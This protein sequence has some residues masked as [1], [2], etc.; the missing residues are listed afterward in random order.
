MPCYAMLCYAMYAMRCDAMRYDAVVTSA[1]SSS[2]SSATTADVDLGDAAPLVDA[3][4][5]QGAEFEAFVR[6]FVQ[7]PGSL[8]T[9]VRVCVR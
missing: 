5:L 9:L 1:H 6:P 4:S 7:N 3:L 2:A 8:D